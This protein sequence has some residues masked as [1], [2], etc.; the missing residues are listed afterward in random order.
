[1]ETGDSF[2][3]WLAILNIDAAEMSTCL[4][5]KIWLCWAGLAATSFYPLFALEAQAIINSLSEHIR[6]KVS[7]CQ[8]HVQTERSCNVPAEFDIASCR[9]SF[10]DVLWSQSF[11]Q[12]PTMIRWI[13]SDSFLTYVL[14]EPLIG[15]RRAEFALA[16]FLCSLK[17]PPISTSCFSDG[18]LDS[19]PLFVHPFW[20][21]ALRTFH[22]YSMSSALVQAVANVQ[23]SDYASC[24]PVAPLPVH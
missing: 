3:L 22:T 11:R 20:F 19:T 1:M 9:R 15:Q 24:E 23:L 18:F 17:G 16:S 8:F 12:P 4:N 2:P 10:S 7:F 13:S 21:L 5:L 6:I 14:E